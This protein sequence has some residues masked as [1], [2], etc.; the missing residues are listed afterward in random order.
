MQEKKVSG[1]IVRTDGWGFW[2]SMV[3]DTFVHPQ[4]IETITV[5]AYCSRTAVAPCYTDGNRQIRL[6]CGSAQT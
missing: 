6:L 1:T 4:L 5:M 2:Q 3:P